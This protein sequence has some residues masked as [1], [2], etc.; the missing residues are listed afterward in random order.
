MHDF[1]LMCPFAV[2][3]KSSFDPLLF[4]SVPSQLILSRTLMK[5]AMQVS[6]VTKLALQLNC[7]LGGEL[8]TVAIPVSKYVFQIYGLCLMPI[9]QHHLSVLHNLVRHLIDIIC[10]HTY[11]IYV[12][13][14]GTT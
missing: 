13:F 2:S 10:N 11:K 8:W 9:P 7:K 4:A 5:K 12:F 3:D 14:S 6:V 1:M